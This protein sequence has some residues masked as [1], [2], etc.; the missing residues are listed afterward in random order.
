MKNSL[1][2]GLVQSSRMARSGLRPFLRNA[3]LPSSAVSNTATPAQPLSILQRPSRDVLAALARTQQ[4]NAFRTVRAAAHQAAALSPADGFKLAHGRAKVAQ[5]E[6][7]EHEKA[8]R[9]AGAGARAL[10]AQFLLAE[11][12]LAPQL[13]QRLADAR[14]MLPAQRQQVLRDV[15]RTHRQVDRQARFEAQAALAQNMP[16]KVAIFLAELRVKASR[17]VL[18]MLLAWGESLREQ[19]A[20]DKKAAEVNHRKSY[21]Q[22]RIRKAALDAKLRLVHRELMLSAA[23]TVQ[24]VAGAARIEDQL[25]LSTAAMPGPMSTARSL[26]SPPANRFLQGAFYQPLPI[27]YTIGGSQSV[28]TQQILSAGR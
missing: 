18:D 23:P 24:E 27:G 12:M 9:A 3:L 22:A 28:Y 8:R 19:A 26:I 7:V 25:V 16:L 2:Q 21:E 11:P 20:L 5:S 4:D 1:L 15:E 17:S 6:L 13:T 10:A 14:L